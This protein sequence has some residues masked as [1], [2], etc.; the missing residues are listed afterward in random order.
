MNEEAKT[1]A[2]VAI[3]AHTK[4]REMY[5]TRQSY[6]NAPDPGDPDDFVAAA[7]DRHMEREGTLVSSLIQGRKVDSF[8]HNGQEMP[9]PMPGIDFDYLYR[10]TQEPRGGE[11]GD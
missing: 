11:D 8:Y 3:E 5:I 4:W 9:C 1:L 6:I 2:R 10:I 7:I